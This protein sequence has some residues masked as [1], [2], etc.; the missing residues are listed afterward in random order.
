VDN[1][2]WEDFRKNE[3]MR[4]LHNISNEEMEALSRVALMGEV[5]SQRDFIYILNTIRQALGR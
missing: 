4:R 2:A 5:R 3:Q 1:T